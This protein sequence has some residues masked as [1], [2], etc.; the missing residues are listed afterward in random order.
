MGTITHS[1]MALTILGVAAS[2]ASLA[3][4]QNELEVVYSS[5][6][7]GDAATLQTGSDTRHMM[8]VHEL[9]AIE[10]TSFVG[11]TKICHQNAEEGTGVS[12]GST[13]QGFCTW[14]DGDGD[15]IFETYD[16]GAPSNGGPVV[17]GSGLIVGGTGKFAGITGGLAWSYN[18]KGRKRGLYYLPG[19]Y[20]RPALLW[21]RFV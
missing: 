9:T 6:W 14:R 12:G 13:Y 10:G 8:R 16:G 2:S 7:I 11:A 18:E 17:F 20:Y 1:A 4:D 19:G 3:A 21:A 5:A 15:L